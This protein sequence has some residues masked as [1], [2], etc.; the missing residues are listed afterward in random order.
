MSV[1]VPF[2]INCHF[3]YQNLKSLRDRN[4]PLSFGYYSSRL[5][6]IQKLTCIVSLIPKIEQ[7]WVMSPWPRP[8][9]LFVILMIVLAVP[10]LCTTGRPASADRTARRQFQA[11]GQPVSRTQTSDGGRSLCVQISRGRSYPLP[12]YWYHLKGKWLRYNFATGSFYIMKLCKRL[13]VLYCRNCPKTT[14]LGNL[15]PFWGS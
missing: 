1:S 13:F 5:I 15:S 9:W 12:I 2:P 8:L 6:C 10:S 7:K 3:I 14:D 11:T 4:T